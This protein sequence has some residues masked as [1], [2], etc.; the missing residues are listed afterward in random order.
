MTHSGAFPDLAARLQAGEGDAAAE[1]VD[2]F[3]RRLAALA[4]RHLHGSVRRH[5]DP[6]DV[7]QSV[8]LT[9]F[10]RQAR[11]QF[12]LG[13]WDSVWRL[14]ACITVRTCARKASRPSP[15][16]ADATILAATFDHRPAPEEIAS[17]ADTV[18]HLLRDLSGR[19][20]DMLR[21]RLEGFSSR[22]VSERVGCTERK[23]QRLLQQVRGR[24]DRLEAQC[25]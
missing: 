9:F 23:V 1:I 8:F 2:R 3:A 20:R 10:C 25:L 11:S 17:L 13:G 24:L 16:L 22:E 18:E 19:E 21:L 12:E 5:L 14:L 7:V 6:E 4:R 15:E